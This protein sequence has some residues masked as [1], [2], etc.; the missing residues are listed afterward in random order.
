MK[1]ISKKTS[2]FNDFRFDGLNWSQ[3][4]NNYL[5][6]SRVS[7]DESKIIV[8]VSRSHILQTKYGY[9][10][11]LDNSHVVF[12]KEWQVSDNYFGVEVLLQKAFW[13]VK[14]WGCFDEFGDEPQNLDFNEWLSTA[15]EQ[16]KLVDEDGNKANRVKWEI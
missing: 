13:T 9:A 5:T 12:L 8:K 1:K 11:I 2:D 3:Y 7:A 10:L 14:E 6:M 16:D 4:S 15:K